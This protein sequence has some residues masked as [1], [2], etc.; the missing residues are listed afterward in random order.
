ML[1]TN[2]KINI[3]KAVSQFST[4]PFENILSQHNSTTECRALFKNEN[5]KKSVEIIDLQLGSSLNLDRV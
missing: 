3:Y 4:K 2:Q 1:L 5:L